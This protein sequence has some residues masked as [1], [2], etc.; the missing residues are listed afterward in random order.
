MLLFSRLGTLTGNPRQAMTWAAEINGYVN[1]H[2]DHDLTLWRADFGFP[3][4]TVAWSTWV[5]SQE[6][7]AA[8]FAALADDDGYFAMLD[9]GAEFLT[10]PAQDILRDAVH[11]GPGDTAPPLGAVA[12]VTTAVIAGG[13]YG[14]AIAWSVEMAQLVEE[15]T[16]LPSSFFVDSFGTFGQVTWISAAPDLATARATGEAINTNDQYLK[17]LSDVGELFVQGS[18]HRSQAT[19]VA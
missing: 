11:G 18:G 6:S 19:R 12:A 14:D 8:G 3:V 15:V 17:R 10:T 1:A 7:M 9:Q 16:K 4:G 5:E 2:S 13:Q